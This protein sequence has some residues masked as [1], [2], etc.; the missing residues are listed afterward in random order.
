MS[1]R[2]SIP[3]QQSVIESLEI[4]EKVLLTGVIYTARDAAHKRMLEEYTMYNNTP[5]ELKDSVVYYA[6]PAPSKPGEIIGSCGPTTSGR[7][8]KYTPWFME[9]GQKVMIGKGIRNQ[10][11]IEA[12]QKHKGIYF[13][14]IGGAGALLANCVKKLDCVAYS[15]LGAEAIYRLE[16]E[17]FPVVVTIDCRGKSLYEEG[18]QKFL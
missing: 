1:K 14:A 3:I 2:V 13:T 15:E 17:D 11:V 9:Q 18:P 4:G 7:M 5:I 12:I 8:D 16:V 10:A 6:G